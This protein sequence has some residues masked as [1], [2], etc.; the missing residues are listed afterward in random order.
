MSDQEFER[1]KA[2]GQTED[3]RSRKI[4][5]Q[6]F[7]KEFGCA[8]SLT[9]HFSLIKFCLITELYIS[10]SVCFSYSSGTNTAS[11]V[12]PS[13]AGKGYILFSVLQLL[14]YNKSEI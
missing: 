14:I 11:P 10:S 8:V 12:R 4:L 2:S 7:Y 5:Y 9:I 1:T 3:V 6:E 13:G